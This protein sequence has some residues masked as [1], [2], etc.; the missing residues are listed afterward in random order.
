M[1]VLRSLIESSSSKATFSETIRGLMVYQP[2]QVT[3]EPVTNGIIPEMEHPITFP[4]VSGFF[5]VL[6]SASSSLWRVCSRVSMVGVSLT[7]LIVP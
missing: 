4:S 1:A 6:P 5:H 2:T 7:F 3:A